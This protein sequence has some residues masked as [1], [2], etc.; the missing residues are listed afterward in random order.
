MYGITETTVHATYKL[1]TGSTIEEERSNIGKPIPTL[2]IHVLDEAL[3]LVPL[4]VPGELV[5]SGA[6]LARGYLNNPELTNKKFCLRWPGGKEGSREA[7]KIRS[8]EDKKLGK[9][10][11]FPSSPHPIPP[12]PHSPIYL[13]GDLARWLSDGDI[14]F[15]G[16]IDHQVKIRGFRIE[17]GEIEYH[18]ST[19]PGIKGAAVTTKKINDQDTLAAYFVNG[20]DTSTVSIA[21]LRNHLGRF[22]P[23]YMIPG[24]FTALE[25]IP[26]TPNG[27]ID[28]K[29]LPDPL[30]TALKPDSLYIAPQNELE[31]KLEIIWEEILGQKKIGINDNFFEIGGNSLKIIRIIDKITRELEENIPVARMFEYPTIHSFA[32]FLS[33]RHKEKFDKD[34]DETKSKNKKWVKLNERKKRVKRSGI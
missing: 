3:R 33:G 25:H 23:D 15:L 10:P 32:E 27:K 22:L 2:C 1:V 19:Y 11:V 9:L 24:Y 8:R 26:L 34:V 6:G 14:E 31:E 16:R 17:L 30:G 13:T 5:I 20:G 28:K 29:S 12:S 4:G 18:L 7:E 21:D